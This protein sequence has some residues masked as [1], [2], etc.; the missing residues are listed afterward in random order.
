MRRRNKV[1]PTLQRLFAG[2]V[3]AVPVKRVT[4]KRIRG[5]P[6]ARRG[7][8]RGQIVYDL[9]VEGGHSFFV[10]GLAVHNCQQCGALDGKVF[11]DIAKAPIPVQSTHPACRCVLS[12]I[13]LSSKALNLPPGTRASFT[14]QV[15]ATVTYRDWLPQQ[16]AAFQREVL[17]P[18]RYKLWKSGRVKLGDFATAAGVKPISA[19]RVVR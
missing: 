7:F 11:K 9:T 19:L 6:T 16:D 8:A 13:V 10:N 18:T 15:P 1:A 3:A 2:C 12:P 5:S 4:R 17:G 14:G